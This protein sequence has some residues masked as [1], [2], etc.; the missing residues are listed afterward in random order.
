[1][2]HR[3]KL[4][5]SATTVD[6]GPRF[7]HQPSTEPAMAVITAVNKD[8]DEI[9]YDVLYDNTSHMEVTAPPAVLAPGDSREIVI[10]FMPR[11]EVAYKE[12]IPIEIN[13]LMTVNVTVKGEGT[14]LRVELA[15]ASQKQ[16][17]FG[18]IRLGS[19]INMHI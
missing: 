16:V 17:N 4:Q 7:L 19:K 10:R 14:P 2:A 1:M 6:F 15:D 11:E 12:V 5:L 18:S 9:S 13:G 8:A 3:P